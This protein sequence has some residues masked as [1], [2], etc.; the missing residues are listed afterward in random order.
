[1]HIQFKVIKFVC[2]QNHKGEPNMD[3][4]NYT[5]GTIKKQVIQKH[6]YKI[7]KS[8]KRN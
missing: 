5:L 8:L 1:M 7:K 2:T 3:K 4:Q 6:F